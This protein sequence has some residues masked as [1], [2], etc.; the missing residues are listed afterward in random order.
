MRLQG[1]RLLNGNS[2]F[3]L[4]VRLGELLWEEQRLATQAR[5]I[6]GKLHSEIVNVSY[7]A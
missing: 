6:R 5:M 7:V 2:V 4:D 1:A 3:T